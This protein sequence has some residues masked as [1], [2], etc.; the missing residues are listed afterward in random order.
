MQERRGCFQTSP[1]QQDIK[2]YSPLLHIKTCR[3]TLAAMLANSSFY[4][5]MHQSVL[6][7]VSD[8]RYLTTC[9]DTINTR[10]SIPK[11]LVYM[12]STCSSKCVCVSVCISTWRNCDSLHRLSTAFWQIGDSGVWIPPCSQTALSVKE[13]K[14]KTFYPQQENLPPAMFSM[15]WLLV[16]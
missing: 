3:H 16:C 9:F 4:V 8:N 14:R 6:P 13:T 5:H 7:Q 2:A 15:L 12:C 10:M 1:L 11:I